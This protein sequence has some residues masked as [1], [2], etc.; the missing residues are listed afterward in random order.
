MAKRYWPND[1]AVGKRIKVGPPENQ[2]WMTI[3][4]VVGN[5]N[6]IGLDVEPDFA[7][8]EPHAK[9]PWSE[10]TLLVRTDIDPTTLTGPIRA[11][12][13]NAESEILIEDVITM[14]HRLQASIA[15]QRLNLVLLASFAFVALV[16]A[17]VGI[18]GVMAQTV[19]QRTHEIGIR[20]AL[21]AQMK[22][23]LRL[24]LR[25]GMTLAVIG[26][27]IG[28]LGA[29]WVTRLMAKLL[30]DVRP[31]DALV[32]ASVAAALF[33]VAFVACYLPARRATKI[34]PLVALRYE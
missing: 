17:A 28:L 34:D 19:A 29:F 14:S 25:N 5:V 15:P 24:V 4:G 16:L 31:T 8:Y 3:V 12:L 27:A 13:K 32:F 6:H 20:M 30:F 2:T 26:V 10:M 9:R 1:D 21:G 18:Y 7:T 23:V 22:D 11:E 33:V